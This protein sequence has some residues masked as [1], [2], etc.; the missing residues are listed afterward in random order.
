MDS[1]QASQDCIQRVY[2]SNNQLLKIKVQG[3]SFAFGQAWDS[4]FLDTLD[5][6]IVGEYRNPEMES[7]TALLLVFDLVS[8]KIIG[9][10]RNSV[11]ICFSKQLRHGNHKLFKRYFLSQCLKVERSATGLFVRELRSC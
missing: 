5:V 9:K 3:L 4:I 8:A 2:C 6:L 10:E 1:L 11:Y 7:R